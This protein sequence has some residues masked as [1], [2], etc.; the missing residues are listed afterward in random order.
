MEQWKPVDGYVGYYEV[1]NMGRVRSVTRVDCAGRTRYSRILKGGRSPKGYLSVGLYKDKSLKGFRVSRLVLAA[2]VGPCP[3]GM[4]AAHNN[5]DERDDRL[6]NL[7]WDTHLNNC[8]DKKLH[9]TNK[10]PSFGEGNHASKLTDE[11]VALIRK[12]ALSGVQQKDLARQF[13]VNRS[14]MSF[15]VRGKTWKHVP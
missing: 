4:E 8:A 9:G 13:G 15:A 2:F 14:T 11:S 3:T 10:A 7:R 1:S 12:L 5:G 6:D